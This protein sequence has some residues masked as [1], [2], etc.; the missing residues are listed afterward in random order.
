MNESSHAVL[1][2]LCHPSP[3][4]SL[5]NKASFVFLHRDLLYGGLRRC[6]ATDLAV[7]AAGGGDDLCGPGGAAFTG[8]TTQILTMNTANDLSKCFIHHLSVSPLLWL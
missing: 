4:E 2:H 3:S 7:S 8:Q 6:D 5:N 1:M